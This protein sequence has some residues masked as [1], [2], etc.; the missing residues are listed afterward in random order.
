VSRARNG[1]TQLVVA[2]DDGSSTVVPVTVAT[3]AGTV[4]APAPPS[5]LQVVTREDTPRE[6]VEPGFALGSTVSAIAA[7]PDGTGTA[8]LSTKEADCP[9]D[10]TTTTTTTTTATTATTTPAAIPPVHLLVCDTDHVGTYTAKLD[11]N[12]DTTGGELTVSAIR[13]RPALLAAIAALAGF[14]LALLVGWLINKATSSAKEAASET[15]RAA[16]EE[17]FRAVEAKLKSGGPA[18]SQYADMWAP[19]KWAALAEGSS[20][21]DPTPEVAFE[22]YERAAVC[23]EPLVK[24]WIHLRAHPNGNDAGEECELARSAN[25]TL[26][27]GIAPREAYDTPAKVVAHL[28]SHAASAHV[29]LRLDQNLLRAL[30]ET[31]DPNEKTRLEAERTALSG[32]KLDEVDDVLETMPDAVKTRIG[33]LEEFRSGAPPLMRRSW[34][35]SIVLLAPTAGEPPNPARAALRSS[36]AKWI[37]LGIGLALAVLAS[38]Q[39]ALN[40]DGGVGNASRRREGLRGIADAAGLARPGAKALRRGLTGRDRASGPSRVGSRGWCA[41]H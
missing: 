25:T 15:K 39:D 4:T 32:A 33:V 13:R 7:G 17:T 40:A 35:T 29:A 2:G 23:A 3:K 12:G 41:R 26:S 18:L 10:G 36:L 34:D 28:E 8:Y 21:T 5:S 1:E 27:Y 31:Q 20:S 11:L 6:T 30:D 22:L 24:L 14:L 16:A 19:L 9:E 37:A 38:M